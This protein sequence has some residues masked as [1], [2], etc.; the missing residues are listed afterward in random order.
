MRG[1][2]GTEALENC[3]LMIEDNIQKVAYLAANE[4]VTRRFFF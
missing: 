3:R 4:E 1:F 2:Y